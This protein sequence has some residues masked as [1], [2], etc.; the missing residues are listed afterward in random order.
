[1]IIVDDKSIRK[2]IEKPDDYLLCLRGYRILTLSAERKGLGA[3]LR[4]HIFDRN[5]YNLL[6]IVFTLRKSRQFSDGLIKT[7]D[8]LVEIY[9]AEPGN[10]KCLTLT[11]QME[12]YNQWQKVVI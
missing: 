4:S 7:C 6:Y 2:L 10:E 3:W 5:S 8:R 11:E 9:N 1:M 12:L